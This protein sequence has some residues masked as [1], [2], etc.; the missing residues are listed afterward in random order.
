MDNLS[1]EEVQRVREHEKQSKNTETL[2][3][4]IDRKL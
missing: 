1:A 4:Q 2:L 3:D